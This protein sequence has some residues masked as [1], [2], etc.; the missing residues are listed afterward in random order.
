MHNVI[1]RVQI[2]TKAPESISADK[3][4]IVI[5]KTFNVIKRL[6]TI[7]KLFLT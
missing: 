2:V 6:N 3:N 5:P 1:A 7:S 4:I